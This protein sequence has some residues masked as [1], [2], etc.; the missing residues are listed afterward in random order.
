MVKFDY[1][2]RRRWGWVRKL[3]PESLE[4]PYTV[5][6]LTENFIPSSLVSLLFP[7]ILP[8]PSS[9]SLSLFSFLFSFFF[10]LF[11][12]NSFIQRSRPSRE[13]IREKALPRLL[14]LRLIQFI[15]APSP[16]RRPSSCFRPLH[17]TVKGKVCNE[18]SSEPSPGDHY[19]IQTPRGR[20]EVPVN[21][22][23][24]LV[25]AASSSV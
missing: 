11:L 6:S 10:S 5:H 3:W 22:P 18:I 7:P 14:L 15:S 4:T 1:G 13:R 16:L 8:P 19:A 2:I 9:P 23:K 21:R 17:S 20:V 25:I 24:P 12:R